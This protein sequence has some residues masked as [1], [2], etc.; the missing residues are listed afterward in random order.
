MPAP[1]PS[2]CL[3]S[4]MTCA[5]GT[6]HGMSAARAVGGNAGKEVG[7]RELFPVFLN[8][9]GSVVCPVTITVIAGNGYL[10]GSAV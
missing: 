8:R 7:E 1:V 6:V 4:E 9:L 10:V 5:A 2:Y 3:G